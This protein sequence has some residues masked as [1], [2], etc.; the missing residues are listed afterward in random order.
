ML[1]YLAPYLAVV[2]LATLASAIGYGTDNI[3]AAGV[4]AF[5]VPALLIAGIGAARWEHHHPDRG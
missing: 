5:M 3:D 4:Y 2:A 1:R